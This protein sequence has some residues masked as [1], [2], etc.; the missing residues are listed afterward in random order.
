MTHCGVCGVLFG[1]Y[2][3]LECRLFDNA[4]KGQFHCDDCH[5]CHTG[6]AENFT[7]CEKCHKCFQNAVM[8]THKCGNVFTGL[9]KMKTKG[10]YEKL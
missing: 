8:E 2:A 3:C 5:V 10:R 1:M 7:H 4:D 6:G 9:F